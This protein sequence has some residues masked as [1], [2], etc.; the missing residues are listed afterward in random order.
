[1]LQKLME[2]IPQKKCVAF[3]SNRNDISMLAAAELSYATADA[4]PEAMEAADQQLKGYSGDAIVRKMSHL[5]ER[6]PWQNL[7]KEL[8]ESEKREG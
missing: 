1:M 7:P 8:R 3:G 2:E 4:I 5:Y 6:L